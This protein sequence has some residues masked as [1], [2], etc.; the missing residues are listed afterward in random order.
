MIEDGKYRTFVEVLKLPFLSERYS[1]ATLYL[2][3]D[4]KSSGEHLYMTSS[5][6]NEDKYTKEYLGAD[7]IANRVAL[8]NKILTF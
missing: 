3:N 8:F 6:G 1:V 2:I 4:Y 5:M 7:F